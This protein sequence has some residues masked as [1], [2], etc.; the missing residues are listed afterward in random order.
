MFEK[1]NFILII[2]FTL[3]LLSVNSLVKENIDNN[4]CKFSNLSRGNGLQNP[5]GL[6]VETYMGEIPNLSKM[7]STVI[8]FPK[9]N[10]EIEEFQPFTIR[11]K[12][13]NLRTGF[14]TD[15][16]TQYYFVPQSLDSEGLIQ[17]HSHIVIQ[18]VKNDFEPLDP[19]VFVF[20][21]G[22]DDQINEQGELITLVDNG[23]PVG[24]YRVC[25]LV[26]SFSHQPTLMPVAQR[27]KYIK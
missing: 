15:P 9:N 14:F 5:N 27:G 21:K 19:N 22:L 2:Y 26:T 6:C 13:I 12:T 1:I 17:G 10:N 8:L 20:F 24:K 16:E 3:I 11:T 18:E 23:L 25:T 7:I 4:I